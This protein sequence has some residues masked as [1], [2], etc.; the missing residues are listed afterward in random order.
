LHL[1]QRHL[2]SLYL[3]SCSF[4]LT[5]MASNS[6]LLLSSSA[7]AVSSTT[8][9]TTAASSSHSSSSSSSFSSSSSS[10][11][12]SLSIF[13]PSSSIPLSPS[14]V[15]LTIVLKV[16][17]SSISAP[18]G[19]IRLSLLSS[20]VELCCSLQKSHR[21]LL[22]SSGAISI[23]CLK[24][25]CPRPIG[26][27]EKQAV[28]AVGQ[29]KLMALYDSLFSLF[30]QPIAQVLLTRENI[31][32]RP[33][34]FNLR[35]T[36]T[37]L[38]RMRVI[39]VI[40]ENDSVSVAELVF[41]DNDTLSSLVASLVEAHHLFLLTDVNSLFSSDPNKDPTA[42]PIH[43]VDNIDAVMHT[44]AGPAAAT[45]ASASTM[46]SSFSSS[47]SSSSSS[48]HLSSTL[49]S[50]SSSSLLSALAP[51][52]SGQWGTGGMATKLAAAR[53]A[54]SAGCFCSIVHGQRSEDVKRILEG[55][56]EVGTT[57]RPSS[58]PIKVSHKRWIAV[59]TD[60]LASFLDL[61]LSFASS[62]S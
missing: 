14:T 32:Q 57:F 41:G 20:L 18:N 30:S 61:S 25:N 48:S 38:M 21:I 24:L 43:V 40:N 5:A 9:T 36:F 50:S 52:R 7:S 39:P 53:V 6:S 58:R 16:G 27:S 15:P 37:E 19:T 55:D 42:M 17:S 2:R 26:L 28:A 60:F 44:V 4:L 49:P 46:N 1:F 23:G 62:R 34:F 45:T 35:N 8:T 33:F 31:N 22:V 13:S 29:S 10:S 11:S 54:V 47:S 56:Y 3:L 51:Q 12:T 59:S